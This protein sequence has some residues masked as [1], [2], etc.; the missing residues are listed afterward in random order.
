M[1]EHVSTSEAQGHGMRAPTPPEL[2]PGLRWRR[3][4]P[5]DERQPGELR[6]WLATLLPDT[7]A[8]DDVT[9]V[10]SELA[11]NA[12]R[13]TA[14]GRDGWFAAEVTWHGSMVQ[15]A[16]ADGGGHSAPH[17]I[18]DIAAENGRGLQLV[19]S[20]SMRSGWCGDER[21]RLVWA[22]VPWQ[23]PATVVKPPTADPYEAAIRDGKTALATR[24]ADVPAWFGRST[25]Q[26]WALGPA[27][28][29]TAPTAQGLAAQLRP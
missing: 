6:R 5:G 4:F 26:W 29:V 16:V 21:G 14:S 25:L 28:L 11:S 8:R 13:H 10:A 12:I 7:P 18:G 1:E 24:F 23:H 17:L 2:V 19:H 9:L 27:G 22:H 15:V 20:L 3:V